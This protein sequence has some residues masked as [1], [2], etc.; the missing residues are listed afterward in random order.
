MRL[1]S[2]VKSNAKCVTKIRYFITQRVLY[3]QNFLTNKRQSIIL[4]ARKPILFR[5]MPSLRLLVLVM[6]LIGVSKLNGKHGH[7][8]DYSIT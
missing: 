7:H 6:A 5:A 2:H 4:K 3:H 8:S 1:H